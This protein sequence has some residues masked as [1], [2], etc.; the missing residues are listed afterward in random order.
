MPPARRVAVMLRP[1]QLDARESETLRGIAGYAATAGWRLL[2]DPF[3]V[4]RPVAAW[5]GLLVPTHWGLGGALA[6]SAVPVV[7]VGWSQWHLSLP[8]AAED[9]YEAGRLAAR[10]LVERGGRRESVR[11]K[12]AKR[13]TQNAKTGSWVRFV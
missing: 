8:Q 11:R 13:K 6:R 4:R 1:D 2:L 5:D 9:R 7:C 3:A 10:H 12:N